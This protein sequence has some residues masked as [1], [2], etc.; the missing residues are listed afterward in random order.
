MDASD[1]LLPETYFKLKHPDDSEAQASETQVAVG[2]EH[3]QA[4]LHQVIPS[5]SMQ[6]LL[7]YE[8]LRDKYSAS[9]QASSGDQGD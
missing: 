5:I 8:Q 2:I 1:E 6:E 9:A 3:L 7:K 4:S